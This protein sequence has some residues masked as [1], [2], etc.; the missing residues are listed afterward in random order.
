MDNDAR[1]ACAGFLPVTWPPDVEGDDLQTTVL[2]V[3]GHE[4]AV[5]EVDLTC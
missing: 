5:L 1:I 4:V 3:A 2:L